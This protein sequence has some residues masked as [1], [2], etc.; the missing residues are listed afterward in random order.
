MFSDSNPDL[1]LINYTRARLVF[2]Q[3]GYYHLSSEK[4][5]ETGLAIKNLEQILLI[6]K[7]E[8]RQFWYKTNSK[9]EEFEIYFFVPT[10]ADRNR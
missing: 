2:D 9:N 6:Y 4:M 5:K 1:F 8:P 7:G 3:G 10:D